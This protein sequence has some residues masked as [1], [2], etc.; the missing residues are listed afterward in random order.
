M[1]YTRLIIRVL[2]KTI[3]LAWHTHKNKIEQRLVIDLEL[4]QPLTSFMRS[5]IY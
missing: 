1:I 5:N 4:H 3:E 2:K